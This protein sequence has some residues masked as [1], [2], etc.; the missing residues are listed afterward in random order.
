MHIQTMIVSEHIAISTQLHAHDYYQ[1]IYCKNGVGEIQINKTVYPARPGCAY[2]ARP[3]EEHTL[4]QI[5]GMHVMEIKFIIENSRFD[6]ELK[7]I[8][9]TFP[10][11]DD[12]QL[13][14]SLKEIAKEGIGNALYSHEATNAALQLFLTRLLR[15]YSSETDIEQQS[16][17]FSLPKGRGNDFERMSDVCFVQVIDYIEKNLDKQITLDDLADVVYF[18]RSY[19]IERFKAVYGIPPMKYVNWKRI[20]KAKELLLTTNKSITEIAVETGF[21]SIHYFSRYFKEKENDT[22]N[23]YRQKRKASFDKNN[24]AE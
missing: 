23:G 17:Y 8:P 16:F 20:E 1:L 24:E 21:Q 19:L 7:K 13:R 6:E 18:N 12:T 11:Y 2:L 4:T 9:E 22:P 10:I 14:L 3:M 15:K 5:D